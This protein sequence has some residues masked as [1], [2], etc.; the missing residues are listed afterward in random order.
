MASPTAKQDLGWL[1]HYSEPVT[2][3]YTFNDY[4]IKK[5]HL[6]T[7][8]SGPLSKKWHGRWSLTTLTFAPWALGLNKFYLLPS[9]PVLYFWNCSLNPQSRVSVGFKGNPGVSESIGI[10]V[11]FPKVLSGN[12]NGGLE[13]NWFPKA[14][15]MCPWHVYGMNT[16]LSWFTLKSTKL[17]IGSYRVETQWQKV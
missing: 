5:A 12:E 1:S 15:G 6:A 9:L 3:L 16:F 11:E 4:L 10:F 8:P 7:P 13:K 2:I 17:F 14:W